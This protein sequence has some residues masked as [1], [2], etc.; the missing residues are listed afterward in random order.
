M[1]LLSLESVE[2]SYSAKFGQNLDTYKLSL[3]PILSDPANFNQNLIKTFEELV[4]NF[5]KKLDADVD[6]VSISFKHE[7]LHKE[8]ISIPFQR[9]KLLTAERIF[10]HIAKVFQSD[11]S[12]AADGKFVVEL[13]VVK[14]PRGNGKKGLSLKDAKSSFDFLRR[15]KSLVQIKNADNLCLPRAIVAGIAYHQWKN[16]EITQSQYRT[17]TRSRRKK[18]EQELRARLLCREVG[19]NPLLY[20]SGKTFSVDELRMFSDYLKSKGYGLAVHD[21]FTANAKSFES[22]GLDNA[23]RWINLL[24]LENHYDVISKPAGFFCRNYHC[25]KCNR[26]YSNKERHCCVPKCAACCTVNPTECIFHTRDKFCAD[27]GRSFFGQACF[28]NHRKLV[29]KMST[30][31]KLRAC[32]ECGELYNSIAR[33]AHE[34]GKSQCC[35]CKL[36]VSFDHLCFMQPY[37]FAEELIV[38][39]ETK[40]EEV[41][42]VRMKKSRYIVWDLETYCLNRT[43][44]TGRLVPHLLVAMTACYNC[45]RRSVPKQA[46]NCSIC[47][48]IHPTELCLCSEE[49]TAN[50]CIVKE[51]KWGDCYECGQNILAIRCGNERLLFKAFFDWIIGSK[52][53]G[54]TLIAHGGSGFDAI[55]LMRNALLFGFHLERPIC[56]GS[57][58]LQLTVKQSPHGATIVRSIDSAQFFQAPL[59]RLPTMFG[60]EQELKKGHFPYKFD[61]PEN[62]NYVGPYPDVEY[63]APQSMKQSEGEALIRWY[64]KQVENNALYNFRREILDYC[65]TDVLVLTAAV[66][67]AYQADEILMGF[68]GMAETCTIASKC[69]LYFRNTFLQ[70]NTIAIIPETGVYGYR[71]QSRAGMEWLL[72]MEHTKFP[73]LQH[74]LSAD[75]E[76]VINRAPVDGYHASSNTILS[77][78]GVYLIAISLSLIFTTAIILYFLF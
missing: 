18:D 60:L 28:D 53:F 59:K 45:M 55:Y 19:L 65:L 16:N 32:A 63:F 71:K 38:D 35:T 46:E 67:A 17:L 72:L 11:E 43:T 40:R 2:S 50:D 13:R 6:R 68:D 30:C 77:F 8:N 26:V 56:R 33:P 42:L 1:S 31:Q 25:A 3:K 54:Y 48:G 23:A 75:G 49:W 5:T 9:S 39:D 7:N 57:K 74:A 62:W 76:K 36:Q 27:C 66:Q 29:G 22:S 34:C 12:I 44:K 41:R 78:E 37:K 14:G 21:S 47:Q 51:T 15:K 20:T 70:P 73:G 58:I 61:Q 24:N 52:R 4:E 10:T 69:N 64:N